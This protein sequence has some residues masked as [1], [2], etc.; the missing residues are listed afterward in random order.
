MVLLGIC[1]A[2]RPIWVL[3]NANAGMILS[4]ATLLGCVNQFL[5]FY[6]FVNSFNF[7]FVHVFDTKLHSCM[8]HFV[9]V[10]HDCMKGWTGF[11]PLEGVNAL[12]WP[13]NTVTVPNTEHQSDSRNLDRGYDHTALRVNEP[14]TDKFT[15]R[16]IGIQTR[17][18]TQMPLPEILTD[19]QV[20]CVLRYLSKHICSHTWKP[21]QKHCGG[22]CRCLAKSSAVGLT[23]SQGAP[24]DVRGG[25][26]WLTHTH[27]HT[28]TVQTSSHSLWNFSSGK[29]YEP[30]FV[31]QHPATIYCH[32]QTEHSDPCVWAYCMCVML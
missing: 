6:I 24:L 21:V 2:L 18:Y 25:T 9:M 29:L 10:T 15:G 20:L 26:L 3:L 14:F 13:L 8:D 31:F 5:V 23:W 16:F 11:L 17:Q 32:Q 12:S 22:A 30:K 27:P 4:P 7:A 28:H 1:R 19:E